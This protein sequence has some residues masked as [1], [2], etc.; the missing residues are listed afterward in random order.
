MSVFEELTEK[1]QNC[2]VTRRGY[3]IDYWYSSCDG[4]NDIFYYDR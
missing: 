1:I 3:S 2:G 4:I